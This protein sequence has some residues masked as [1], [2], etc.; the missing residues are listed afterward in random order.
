MVE[1]VSVYK[2][3]NDILNLVHSATLLEFKIKSRTNN[4]REKKKDEEIR[5]SKRKIL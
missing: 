1:L 2:K 4:T 3:K 5:R